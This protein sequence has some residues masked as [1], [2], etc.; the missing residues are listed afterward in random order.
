MQLG[1]LSA[2]MKERF[3]M[4]YNSKNNAGQEQ[5]LPQANWV[6]RIKGE[7]GR[8]RHI[9]LNTLLDFVQCLCIIYSKIKNTKA[10]AIN[11]DKEKGEDKVILPNYFD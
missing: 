8:G 1:I 2:L 9:S 7:G 6:S 10:V 11:K 4:I 3:L 5:W